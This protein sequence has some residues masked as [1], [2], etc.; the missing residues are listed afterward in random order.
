VSLT[1]NSRI[2]PTHVDTW[3]FVQKAQ[4]AAITAAK[5]GTVTKVVDA[6]ARDVFRQEKLDQ[7]FTHRLGHGPFIFPLSSLEHRLTCM[8]KLIP[9]NEHA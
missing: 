6:A 3:N 4:Q 5:N 2:P 1:A 7:Y 8:T 9:F